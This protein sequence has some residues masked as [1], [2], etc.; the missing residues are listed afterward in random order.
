MVK[1]PCQEKEFALPEGAAPRVDRADDEA[2][3][4]TLPEQGVTAAGF[5]QLR[6]MPHSPGLAASLL[7]EGAGPMPS[8]SV[9]SGSFPHP[10]HPLVQRLHAE[11]SH[12]VLC[13]HVFP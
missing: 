9:P 1:K 3:N 5:G 11:G 6:K 4:E 12:M 10:S 7:S 8:R 2:V 13:G